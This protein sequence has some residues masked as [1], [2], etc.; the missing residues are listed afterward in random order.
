MHRQ[1][2]AEIEVDVEV[3]RQRRLLLRDGARLPRDDDV[4]AELR[5]AVALDLEVAA[6]GAQLARE[7][8]ALAVEAGFAF[9]G[10]HQA[11][12]R[13]LEQPE[14]ACLPGE[15]GVALG[16]AQGQRS[17]GGEASL[18]RL[19]AE[20]FD[21]QRVALDARAQLAVLEIHA[22]WR[23]IE[24]ERIAAQRARGDRRTA[25]PAAFHGRPD[26]ALAAPARAHPPPG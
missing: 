3:D 2:R 19:D 6:V 10:G 14:V 20:A 11:Q 15:L 4:V 7:R 21:A 16:E 22:E 8:E 17:G 18:A 25:R 5:N 12:V 9:A 26:A 13:P 23:G 24:S 1:V